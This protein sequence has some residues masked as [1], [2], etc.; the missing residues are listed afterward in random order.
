MAALDQLPHGGEDADA[1]DP[2]QIEGNLAASEGLYVD[3]QPVLLGQHGHYLA[4]GNAAVL[5]EPHPIERQAEFGAGDLPGIQVQGHGVHQGAVHIE[6]QGVVL[7]KL[8]LLGHGVLPPRLK[9]H[10]TRSAPPMPRLPSWP[11][12]AAGLTMGC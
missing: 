8:E 12:Q 9:E 5:I 6:D 11:G 10:T 2:L 7:L 4:G 1:V 3:G